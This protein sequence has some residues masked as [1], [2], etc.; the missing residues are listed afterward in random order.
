MMPS[1]ASVTLN[2][3]ML[4][5]SV[6]IWKIAKNLP[7]LPPHQ[8]LPPRPPHHQSCS[9]IVGVAGSMEFLTHQTRMNWIQWVAMSTAVPGSKERYR[10]SQPGVGAVASIP[11]PLAV[12][13][14]FPMEFHMMLEKLWMMPSPASVTVNS[15]T[16]LISVMIW[17]IAKT[18][19]LPSFSLYLFLSA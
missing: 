6:M 16:L 2:S 1:P 19:P 10:V 8:N 5:I 12:F 18:L 7:P 9:A 17:K 15:A 13:R 11:P 3:A 4:L 14:A